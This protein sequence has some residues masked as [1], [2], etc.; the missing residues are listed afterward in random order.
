[1]PVK[2]H[3]SVKFKGEQSLCIGRNIGK[4]FMNSDCSSK[5]ERE[6]LMMFIFY[7]FQI[8]QMEQL[9]FFV[10]SLNMTPHSC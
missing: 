5:L 8:K 10:C 4:H 6:R 7:L 3:I 1:M 9:S 2:S